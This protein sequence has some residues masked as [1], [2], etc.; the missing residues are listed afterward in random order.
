VSA[1]FL[2]GPPATAH[3]V[4]I[5]WYAIASAASALTCAA[6]RDHW[7]RYSRNRHRRSSPQ[8]NPS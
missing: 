1:R 8:R 4:T 6:M 7:H 5:A 2:A 3:G